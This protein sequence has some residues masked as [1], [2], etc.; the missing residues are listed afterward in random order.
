MSKGKGYYKSLDKGRDG[1]LA[2]VDALLKAYDMSLFHNLEIPA[3]T[4]KGER[5]TTELDV[6]LITEKGIFVIESK[7]LFCTVMGTVDQNSWLLG[8]GKHK[9]VA[10]QNPIKQNEYHVETLKQLFVANIS[11]TLYSN[12]DLYKSVIIFGNDAAIDPKLLGCING[13]GHKDTQI[14][15]VNEICLFL[16]RLRWAK[17]VM[18]EEMVQEVYM[19][20]TTHYNSKK[21]NRSNHKIDWSIRLDVSL[22]GSVLNITDKNAPL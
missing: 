8:Y 15:K 1:E 17:P 18:S 20:L 13:F 6:V 21:R 2:I 16:E 9:T 10:C 14:L 11:R 19:Y 22:T 12:D 4:S 5:K 3:S 7:N